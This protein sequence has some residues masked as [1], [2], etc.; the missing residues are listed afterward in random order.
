MHLVSQCFEWF[1]NG[2]VVIMRVLGTKYICEPVSPV[3]TQDLPLPSDMVL[4]SRGQP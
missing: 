1:L 4:F 3:W 2:V